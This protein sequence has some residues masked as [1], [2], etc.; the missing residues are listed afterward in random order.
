MN[1]PRACRG[2]SR[3]YERFVVIGKGGEFFGSVAGFCPYFACACHHEYP[4]AV[5]QYRVFVCPV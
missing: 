2:E 3:I 1:A 5:E 4:L